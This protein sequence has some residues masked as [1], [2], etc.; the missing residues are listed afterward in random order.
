MHKLVA[1]LLILISLNTSLLSQSQISIEDFTLKNTFNVESVNS[2]NWMKDG[3]FYSALEDNKVVKYDV[4]TGVAVEEIVDGSA[5]SPSL[6]I[7]DY[8]FSDDETK[9]LL[10]T[11]RQSVFRRSYTAVFYVYDIAAKAISK[12]SEGRQAYGT[13]SPDGTKV[14]FTR[15]NNLFWKDVT[16]GQEAQITSDGK[17]NAIIN[18]STDWVYEE[19]LYLTKAFEWSPDGQL[20]AYYKFDESLVKEYN[21]QVWHEGQLYPEDYRYKYPKAGELNSVVNI[22]IYEVGAN[23]NVKADIGSETDTYIPRIKW[24]KDAKT[25]SI[26]RLNR[27]QN[28]LDILHTDAST[29]KSAI[30]L[31]DKSETYIDFTFCDDLTYLEDDK[32][33]LFSSEKS[34]FK[35]FYLYSLSGEL[36]RQITNGSWEAVSLA[37]VDQSTKTPV[38]FYTSTEDSPMERAFY[39]IDIKGK[40]K[41]KLSLDKGWNRVVMSTD[42]RFYINYF[43]SATQ[44]QKVTLHQSKGNKLVKVLK[45]NAALAK[46]I[47]DHGFVDKEFFSFTTSQGSNLNGYFLKPAD[48]D[49]DKKYPVLLYQYSGPGSQNAT[50][51]WGGGHFFWHQML[52]QK[53]YIVAVVDTRGTG[54]R[55]ER[56]KK[57]TYKQLGK[58]ETEDHIEAARYFGTLPFVDTSRI[59]IWGWSYGGYMSS[60]VLF[61]G[62]DLFKAAIAVAPVTTW[63]FYDTIYTERYLMRP[64]DN[65]GGYDD[66]SPITH[67]DKLKGNFL[68]IHGTGDDNVHFQN[69]VA[70]QDAL[71]REGKQF[72][73]FYYPDKTHG[74]SGG[75]YR[76]HLYTMM[77]N[78]ITD[79]L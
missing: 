50:N 26:Q 77:T 19:E 52:T 40:N 69:S 79:N 51:A 66:N 34:G 43:T 68:L 70:L 38:L 25:L 10:L 64:Q 48:F 57:M 21:M 72:E 13:F 75:K 28:Q 37:G 58:Y 78:F 5:L 20:I 22:F 54:G 4:T 36:I 71:I 18:G 6:K 31:T 11:D 62:A 7:D 42:T 1:T 63:R 9:L 41:A 23:R 74:I 35:H 17:R 76:Y 39:R 65:A 15:D 49:S 53:G 44:P 47:Q 45:D 32:T 60:L 56:F 46:A 59:G 55:G 33:F 73:S 29:G 16:S 14:A 30:I 3:Q 24:L 2:V 67:A 8:T 27:L 12:L 61:K